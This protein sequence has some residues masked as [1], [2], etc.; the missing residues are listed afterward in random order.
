LFHFGINDPSVDD[1]GRKKRV[2]EEV[3][4]VFP[5]RK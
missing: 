1:R 5:V 3:A 2:C 4:V